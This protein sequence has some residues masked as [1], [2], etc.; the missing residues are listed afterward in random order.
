M[1]IY[2][3]ALA[4]LVSAGCSRDHIR[5][6]PLNKFA[7]V[8]IQ[9]IEGRRIL[10][11]IGSRHVVRNDRSTLVIVREIREERFPLLRG[12]HIEREDDTIS[13]EEIPTFDPF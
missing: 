5:N 11:D 12:W 9:D 8:Y 6:Y 3:L 2:L 13:I 7:R 10:I 1:K 4:L